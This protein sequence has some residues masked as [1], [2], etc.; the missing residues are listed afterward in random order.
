M[1]R[2]GR[3]PIAIVTGVKIEKKDERITVR[4]PKGELSV[5]V[6]ATIHF[7]IKDDQIVLT[8]SDD[9]K[10]QKSLHGTWRAHLNN[11]VKGVSDGFQKKLEIVG[12]GYKAEMK[13]SKVQL[14]LGYSHPILFG[15]PKGI[16]VQVPIPTNILISGIDRQLV[17]QVAAKLRSFR[18]PEP[19]KGKGVKYEGEYIRRKAGKAAA[20]AG[21][22]AG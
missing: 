13:G 1:S 11:M 5:V 4:G 3:K 7:E 2:I 8:R 17:G 18:P 20:T 22:K 6:P 14:V 16:T 15:P 21:A 12:V 10:P 19:Y 9:T